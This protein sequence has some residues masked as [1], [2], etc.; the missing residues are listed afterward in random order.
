MTYLLIVAGAAA[1]APLRYFL[2]Q[3]VQE[4]TSDPFPLGT[5][6]VN[7]SGCLAIGVL[8]ALTEQYGFL[9]REARLILVTGFLGSYTTFSAFGLET[10]NL[11]RADDIARLAL[12][13][14]L[15]CAMGVAAVAVG[16]VLVRAYPG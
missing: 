16:Y 7:I 6:V 14:G 11:A 8:A 2:Q 3:R 5:L 10:Y 15:S 1:G 13:V 4:Q 12:N 9:N